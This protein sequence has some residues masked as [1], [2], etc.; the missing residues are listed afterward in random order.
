M[1][2]SQATRQI[3]LARALSKLGYCS[4][5]RAAELIRAGRVSLNG[6]IRRDP[7]TPVS[8]KQNQV[9]VD[10]TVV[11]QREKIYLMLNKP[12]GVLTTA[13]DE[14]GRQTVYAFLGEGNTA[15]DAH[16]VARARRPPRQSQRRLA[17]ADQ[18]F[19]MGRAH[20]GA[21]N[22]FG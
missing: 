5:S 15:A 9:A 18:R 16:T 8:G 14:K 21:G 2:D 19:G 22:A 7:E 13:S 4:R 3:G 6:R 10:G 12:R 17:V 20:R 11:E 1:R